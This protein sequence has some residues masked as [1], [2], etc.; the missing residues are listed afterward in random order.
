M[1]VQ[2]VQFI[3][4]SHLIKPV[5][6]GAVTEQFSILTYDCAEKTSRQAQI[7]YKHRNL[8]IFA[9]YQILQNFL[10]GKSSN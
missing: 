3:T 1:I 8:V 4:V 5:N 10:G 7:D 2:I 9:G 6:L